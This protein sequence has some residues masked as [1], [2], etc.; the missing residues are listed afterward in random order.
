M[1]SRSKMPKQIADGPV[2]KTRVK[3][4]TP[5]GKPATVSGA[6]QKRGEGFGGM[7]GAHMGKKSGRC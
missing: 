2:N 4:P 3:K 7:S 1:M 5:S 6:A